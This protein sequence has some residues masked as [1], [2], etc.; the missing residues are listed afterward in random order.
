[1]N[2]RELA[3]E[4]FKICHKIN[5]ETGFCAFFRY[6]GHVDNYDVQIAK[7]KTSYAED[8]YRQDIYRQDWIPLSQ[9]LLIDLQHFLNPEAIE[10]YQ[11]KVNYNY[12]NWNELVDAATVR[13]T[14][15]Q[16]ESLGVPASKIETKLIKL[17][18]ARFQDQ[19]FYSDEL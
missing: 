6:A 19:D 14:V 15:A 11:V 5:T 13:Q 17:H 16:L 7:G 1:V 8:I 12:I 3:A 10:C 9:G 18:R 2:E 4:I